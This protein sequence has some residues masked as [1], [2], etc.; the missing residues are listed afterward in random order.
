MYE[1]PLAH[2]KPQQ[3]IVIG[4]IFIQKVMQDGGGIIAK[5]FLISKKS[6]RQ[7]GRWKYEL[8]TSGLLWKHSQ[9]L[10][11]ERHDVLPVE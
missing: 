2:L 3:S 5:D 8:K 1:Q 7:K 4:L 9:S 11:T 6:K 10:A